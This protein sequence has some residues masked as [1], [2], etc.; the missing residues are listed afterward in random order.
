[1]HITIYFNDKPLFLTDTITDEIAPFAHHDDAVYM[2]ELSAPG[3]NSMIHEMKQ[4]KVHAG[5]YFHDDIEQL[6]KAFWR[7]FMHIQAA[8]AE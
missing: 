3:V 6:R 4:E 7:K 8:G 2:D 5:I 1:M